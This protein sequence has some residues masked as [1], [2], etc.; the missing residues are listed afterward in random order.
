MAGFFVR[1]LM[2]FIPVVFLVITLTFFLVRLAP[3]GPF[4]GEKFV[5]EEALR[6]IE[7]QYNLDAPLF[8]QYWDY[9]TDVLR[10]DLGPSLKRPNRSVTEWIKLKFPVSLEL[11][12]YGLF[13]ALFIGLPAGVLA[14]RYQNTWID[15]VTMSGATAGIC[16][17]NF[18]LGPLLV[19][20]FA[21]WLG[22]LPVALWEKPVDKILP[23][24]TLGVVY[25]AYIAR[26]SR[27][28]M[29]EVLSQDFIRTARAK[30]LSEFQVVFRHA[31]PGALQPVVAFLGPAAAGL[32]TGSFVVENI[33]RVPGLG[34]E[35]IKA[36]LN[37]DY[38]MIMGT[39]LVFAVLIL[40]FNLLV[41]LIHAWIDPRLRHD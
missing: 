6:Q 19:L 16:I 36:A 3:G 9:L 40:F 33:F 10:G 20:V 7:A 27:T 14:A 29:I 35:F 12:L 24:L 23:S 2:E 25:A 13:V 1:R 18:V 39:V 8:V 11:G 38:T 4:S 5:S 17:P 34:T 31:L 28:A 26:L 37:R 21:I 41:D 15:R 32:L 30:G 22:W